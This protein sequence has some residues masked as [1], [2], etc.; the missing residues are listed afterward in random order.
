LAVSGY[1]RGTGLFG[2]LCSFPRSFPHIGNIAV[3]VSEKVLGLL[4]KL[5]R[6][7]E[8]LSSVTFRSR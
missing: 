3:L 8:G 6:F 5:Q 2:S 7:V 1:G 4:E